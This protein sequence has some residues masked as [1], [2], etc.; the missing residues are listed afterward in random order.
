MYDTD[1]TRISL[2]DDKEY[3]YTLGVAI[4]VFMSVNCFVIENILHTDKT[5]SWHKLIDKTSG[6]LSSDMKDTITKVAGPEIAQ[7]FNECIEKRNR[8]LHGFRCTD[9][10]G[11]QAIATKTKQGEQFY[12]DMEFLHDFIDKCN[13]LDDK[14]EKY[15]EDGGYLNE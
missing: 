1:L 7:M 8:I 3:I 2:P 13:T 14:L 4:S 5:K 12:I 6:A 10:N 11:K 15:R 9:A